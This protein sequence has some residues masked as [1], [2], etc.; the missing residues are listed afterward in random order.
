MSSASWKVNNLHFCSCRERQEQLMGYRKR[1]PKPKH[2]LLQVITIFATEAPARRSGSVRV[3]SRHDLGDKD[4]ELFHSWI[5]FLFFFAVL[6]M[7]WGL[8]PEVT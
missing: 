8:L 4:W 1:G 5:F 3:F 7:T 2:L 6:I